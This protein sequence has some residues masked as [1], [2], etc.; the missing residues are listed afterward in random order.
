M[1]PVIMDATNDERIERECIRYLYREAELL[2]NRKFHEWLKLLNP[3]IDYRVP[4]R[5]SRENAD[6]DGFSNK[7]F[8]ME[9][10]YESLKARVARLDSKFAWSENPA[11]RT[12]RLVTNFRVGHS[13]PAGE[14]EGRGE[15]CGVASN[16]AVYCFRGESAVPLIL[17]GERQDI[18]QRDGG[19]WT[20]LSRLVLLDTTVLGMESLS[21]FL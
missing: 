18:L 6:G 10:D 12:R 11:T 13:A 21:I 20:L 1:K 5:T 2:D 9:E 4:V 3:K 19:E 14:T 17:T 15:S 7:A 8:F 16:F